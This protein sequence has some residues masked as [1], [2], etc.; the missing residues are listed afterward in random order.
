MSPTLEFR[1]HKRQGYEYELMRPGLIFSNG[2]GQIARAGFN[3]G[4]PGYFVFFAAE[5]VCVPAGEQRFVPLHLDLVV[6]PEFV[7]QLDISGGARE[8]GLGLVE[9]FLEPG[10][11]LDL[12]VRVS[13]HT[14][15]DYIIDQH[16]GIVR[17]YLSE[18]VRPIVLCPDLWD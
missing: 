18:M 10:E 16:E 13:N 9:R 1:P 2:V 17:G 7:M 6:P 4:L 12:G 8:L 5:Q 15:E 11:H 14:G 3:A